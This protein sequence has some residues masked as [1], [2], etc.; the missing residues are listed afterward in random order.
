MLETGEI[1]GEGNYCDTRIIKVIIFLIS[2]QRHVTSM[3]C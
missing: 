1:W 3:S 2:G